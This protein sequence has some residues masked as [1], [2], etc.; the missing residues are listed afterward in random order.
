[1]DIVSPP[2]AGSYG[3]PAPRKDCGT[4]MPTQGRISGTW[5]KV[6]RV[7]HSPSNSFYIRP[8][9]PQELENCYVK[10]RL[11]HKSLHSALIPAIRKKDRKRFIR[12]MYVKQKSE[13]QFLALLSDSKAGKRSCPV[14]SSANISNR[15]L[16]LPN[17]PY[18]PRI[19]RQLNQT[20][21]P[22]RSMSTVLRDSLQVQEK[23]NRQVEGYRRKRSDAGSRNCGVET[24]FSG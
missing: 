17:S 12:E 23:G 19:C 6:A 24:R 20:R 21:Q 14:N 22:T 13:R 9:S 4:D 5:V 11:C 10:S 7:A 1:M 8:L 18:K 15:S 3:P 2:L 16:F